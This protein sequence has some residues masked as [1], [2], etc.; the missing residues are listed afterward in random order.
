MKSNAKLSKDRKY[1]YALWR[2]WEESRPKVMFIGL[3]PSTADETEDDPTIRRCIGFA[4]SWGYGGLIMANLFGFRATQPKDL[5]LA[6]DPIGPRNNRW[7]HSL[8]NEARII[9]GAWGNGGSF[10]GR[11]EN[12][13]SKFK[14]L[15]VLKRTL[16][17]HPVHPLYQP[18]SAMP[19][20]LIYNTK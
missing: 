3:N 5:M 6:K 11:G 4:R 9:I 8:S 20:K 19:E 1:R 14:N 2:I 12:I 17:G 18:R 15:Y 13:M 7:L 16:S 10:L